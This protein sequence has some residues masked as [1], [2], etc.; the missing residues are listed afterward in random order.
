MYT[1]HKTKR[2]KL[3]ARYHLVKQD[4]HPVQLRRRATSR[5]SDLLIALAAT[6]AESP[7]VGVR[8]AVVLSETL[9]LAELAD[10]GF[11]RGTPSWR[12]LWQPSRF[13]QR[14][15]DGWRWL[16]Q[17]SRLHQRKDGWWWL[18]R[19]WRETCSQCKWWWW[20]FLARLRPRAFLLGWWSRRWRQ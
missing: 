6:A 18:G 7:P 17:P 11:V 14:I 19:W 12:W 20:W 2:A 15:K 9:A 4:S 10:G 13:H 1:S 3:A 8:S 5:T 16:W